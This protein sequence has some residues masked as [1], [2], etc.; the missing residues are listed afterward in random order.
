MTIPWKVI[1]W[2][3]CAISGVV[4]TVIGSIYDGNITIS[5]DSISRFIWCSFTGGVLFGC[6]GYL[7]VMEAMGS[8]ARA[9]Q[10]SAPEENYRVIDGIHFVWMSKYEGARLVPHWLSINGMSQVRV[11][12]PSESVNKNQWVV[13]LY[14]F[15]GEPIAGP[16]QN[17][18][19]NGSRDCYAHKDQ[20]LVWVKAVEWT[21]RQPFEYEEAAKEEDAVE[22]A[23]RKEEEEA[24]KHG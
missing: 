13:Y 15:G 20:E 7:L 19:R 10:P 23:A 11:F 2:V 14:D 16:R 24:A 17:W 4:V 5:V 1:V 21:R 6:V 22:E 3:L 12:P 9:G 18:S 8:K